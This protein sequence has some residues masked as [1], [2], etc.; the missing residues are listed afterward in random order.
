[1]ADRSYGMRFDQF[2]QFVLNRPKSGT[3]P[4]FYAFTLASRGHSVVI[5]FGH[6]V[7][8][9]GFSRAIGNEITTGRSPQS[10]RSVHI[11]APCRHS[12]SASLPGYLPLLYPRRE[13][14][15]SSEALLDITSANDDGDDTVSVIPFV[16]RSLLPS[17]PA[18]SRNRKLSIDR[19]KK[20]FGV[21]VT[22]LALSLEMD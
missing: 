12:P 6:R 9:S 17:S 14:P 20:K 19:S 2:G 21:A 16:P 10:N 4:P 5:K 18:R 1:M 7:R 11:L 3:I 13:R 22:Q 8:V 15:F